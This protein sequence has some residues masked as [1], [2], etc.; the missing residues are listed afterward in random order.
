MYLKTANSLEQAIRPEMFSLSVVPLAAWA[1][2]LCNRFMGD[3]T[4]T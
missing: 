3:Y 1:T 2:V 4:I